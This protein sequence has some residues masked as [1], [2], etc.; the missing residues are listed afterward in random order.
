LMDAQD[1][2]IHAFFSTTPI[3]HWYQAFH[4]LLLQKFSIHK[5][6]K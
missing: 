3:P 2:P 6:L 5:L 1:K 4:P